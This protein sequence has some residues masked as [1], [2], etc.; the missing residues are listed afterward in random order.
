LTFRQLA[1]WTSGILVLFLALVTPLSLIADRYLF[2]AHMLQHVLLTLIAPP[3]LYLGMPSWFFDPLKRMPAV[4][5]AL[6]VAANPFVAFA[7]FNITFVAWH[8]PAL[9][10][11]ALYSAEIHLLE[12]ATMFATAMLTWLP[13]LS[14]TRLLPRL[15]LPAQ[16][17]YLFLQSFVGTGLGALIT[18]AREPIYIFYSQA[19]RFWGISALDD[20]VWAGLI[21]WVGT[22]MI[23]LLA[24]TIVF[25]RWFGA[26]GPIEGEHKFI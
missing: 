5:R 3:L 6:R 26:G 8:I 21:M 19:S 4:L 9:Y 20:Q 22:A 12:H 23:F 2:S 24:L 17:L 13:V 11:L 15:P 16:V 14:P 1:W 18:L 10:N 7:A 25:F